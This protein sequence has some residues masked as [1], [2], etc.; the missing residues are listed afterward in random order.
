[1]CD[2]HRRR[3]KAVEGV[4]ASPHA[5]IEIGHLL[6]VD[7]ESALIHGVPTVLLEVLGKDFVKP[8]GRGDLVHAAVKGTRGLQ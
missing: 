5:L 6:A 2:W 7:V 4:D 1:M 8:L 3:W